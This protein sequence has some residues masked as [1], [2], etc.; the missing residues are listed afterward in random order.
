MSREKFTCSYSSRS[1]L[2]FGFAAWRRLWLRRDAL[3]E[4]EGGKEEIVFFLGAARKYSKAENKA[5]TFLT[6]L[7]TSL[8]RFFKVEKVN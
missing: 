2:F 8:A 5:R 6:S 4:N 3:I 7:S 1:Q